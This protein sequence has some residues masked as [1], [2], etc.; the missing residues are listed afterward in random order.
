MAVSKRVGGFQNVSP[1]LDSSHLRLIPN[2]KR[3]NK[4]LQISKYATINLN[5]ALVIKINFVK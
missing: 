2:A 5:F 1:P 4:Q 3:V